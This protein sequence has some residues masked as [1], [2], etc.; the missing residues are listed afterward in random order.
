MGLYNSL[1]RWNLGNSNIVHLQIESYWVLKDHVHSPKG[2]G[3]LVKVNYPTLLHVRLM[4]RVDHGKATLKLLL[5]SLKKLETFSEHIWRTPKERK[6]ERTNTK[7]T[8]TQIH[9]A[10]GGTLTKHKKPWRHYQNHARFGSSLHGSLLRYCL[11]P[12]AL[13]YTL[14]SLKIPPS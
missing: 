6:K 8:S 4:A 12:W 10:F 11:W 7:P 2:S 3:G 1:L 14:K 13:P 5:S 9:R